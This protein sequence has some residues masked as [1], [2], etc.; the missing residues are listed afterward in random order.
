MPEATGRNGSLTTR[1]QTVHLSYILSF[2]GLF[3]LPRVLHFFVLV[4]F[5]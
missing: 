5:V 4:G 1:Q 2:S 3:V